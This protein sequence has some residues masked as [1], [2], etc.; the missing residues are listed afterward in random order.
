MGAL[1]RRGWMAVGLGGWMA[2]V[3]VALAGLAQAAEPEALNP[4]GPVKTERDDAVPGYVELS[5]GKVFPGNVYMTRDKRLKLWDEKLS[6]QREIPLQKVKEIECK[7]KKEWMEKEW[8]FK[9]LALDEKM[10]T[11]R[12]Y[13]SREYDH[14]VTLAD[15]RKLTGQLSEI[16][17]VQPFI[18]SPEG[19]SQYR[20]DVAP[21][22]FLLHKRQKGEI[23]T[24]LKSLVY[25]KRV[26]LGDEAF[27][28]GQQKAKGRGADKQTSREGQGER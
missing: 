24:T 4:F 13:P 25:V 27:K 3:L 23:N 28:E 6:R 15:G 8:R 19:P 7:V 22:K 17:F 18:Y 2:G 12:S 10:Y 16:L 5:N 21:D 11:G 1:V 20:P 14:V 9:E 26:K